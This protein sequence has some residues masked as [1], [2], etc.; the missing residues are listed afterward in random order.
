MVNIFDLSEE[1]VHEYSKIRPMTATLWG[2]PGYDDRWDDFSST[3]WTQD[4]Q[5]CEEYERRMSMISFTGSKWEEVAFVILKEFLARTIMYVKNAD[6]YLDIN[7][8]YCTF[9]QMM[10]ALKAQPTATEADWLALEKRLQSFDTAI[11]QYISALRD[12]YN[13]GVVSAR[14]QVVEVARQ[15]RETNLSVLLNKKNEAA[16][17]L[18]D[19]KRLTLLCDSVKESHNKLADFLENEYLQ[20]AR[21][22][23]ACG[24]EYYARCVQSYI[25]NPVNLEDTYQWGFEEIHRLL[26]EIRVVCKKIDPEES[27]YLRVLQRVR[28]D[29]EFLM[30][31]HDEFLGFVKTKELEAM[32][33]LRPFFDIPEML[34]T[35]NVEKIPVDVDLAQYQPPPPDFS[36]PGCISYGFQ[37]DKPIALFDQLTTAYH[38]GFPGHHLQCGLQVSYKDNLSL[39]GRISGYSGYA[40]GWALYAERFMEEQGLYEHAYYTLGMLICS[41]FR[42]CRIVIDI[43]LHLSLR[44]PDDFELNPGKTWCFELGKSMLMDVCGFP[45]KMSTDEMNRYCGFPGQAISYKVGERCIRDLRNYY[46]KRLPEGSLKEF[47]NMILQYGSVSLDFLET[48]VKSEID[49]S[50]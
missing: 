6:Y 4:L 22:Q 9:Q 39:L 8:I 26:D 29:P 34:A 43:G 16:G 28:N 2:I 10:Y 42:A 44:I 36:R 41:L 5:L 15:A 33:K 31:D 46:F 50:I 13:L 30:T 47:H 23:D 40:E 27:D 3:S 17:V 38:E 12:G 18:M 48:H 24:A 1:F 14:R 19:P 11:E 37:K 20:H 21:E 45:E 7:S 35:I 49:E 25:G 32:D